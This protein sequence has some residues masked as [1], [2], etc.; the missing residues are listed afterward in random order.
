M[1]RQPRW[2]PEG[3][4]YHVLNRAAGRRAIF[5]EP[6]DAARFVAVLAEAI[7]RTPDAGLLGWCLMPNHWHLVFYPTADDVLQP[8]LHWLT[9]TH[10]QRH[11]AAH[12][13]VGD[14]H[15]YQ[16]RYRSFPV[17]TDDHLL[18][19]LRYVER[20]PVRAGLVRYA[21]DWAWSSAA[22][23][24]ADSAP[25]PKLSPWPVDRPEKWLEFVD[26]PLTSAEESDQLHKLHRAARRGSPFGAADWALVTAE[27][28]GLVATLRPL[29][30]PP[31]G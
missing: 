13:T 19:V 3:L 22:P 28:L 21:T 18:I 30:R 8:M 12:R 15:L 23:T 4:A 29:G 5:A 10:T 24:V 25:P 20:N 9:L 7:E 6:R 27:R 16:G 14:G 2:M 17:A 1:P 31:R 11:R 26:Q